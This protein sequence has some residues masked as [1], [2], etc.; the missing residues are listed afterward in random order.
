MRQA[1]GRVPLLSTTPRQRYSCP[2]PPHAEGS[3]LS[4]EPRR[5][6]LRLRHT[7]AEPRPQPCVHFDGT[8]MQVFA[9]A[10]P[11]TWN[12]VPHIVYPV[13]SYCPPLSLKDGAE[14]L[15]SV[16]LIGWD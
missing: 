10:A 6:G 15:L 12:P 5:V 3:D 14:M 11:S 9:H 8:V 16:C 1:R 13:P 7:C 4:C 2:F